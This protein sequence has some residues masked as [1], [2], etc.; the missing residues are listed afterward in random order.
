MNSQ[1]A[2][3]VNKLILV[4]LGGI[5]ACLVLLVVRIYQPTPTVANLPEA[6]SVEPADATAQAS[7]LEPGPRPARRGF[8]HA[9]LGLLHRQLEAALRDGIAG[10]WYDDL[11][12]E[13]PSRRVHDAGRE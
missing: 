11:G 2:P 10:L 7:E 1:S 9:L 8:D 6:E 3:L 12:E 4:A 5:L 13:E